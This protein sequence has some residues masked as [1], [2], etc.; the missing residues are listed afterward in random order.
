MLERNLATSRNEAKVVDDEQDSLVA[1]LVPDDVGVDL[2]DD[3]L[4]PP[5][6]I[7]EFDL[8]G[9]AQTVEGEVRDVPLRGV[10]DSLARTTDYR[11]RRCRCARKAHRAVPGASSIGRDEATLLTLGA[12]YEPR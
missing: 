12:A 4:F 9:E 7:A 6:S 2:V 10:R 8:Y 11:A 3:L 5:G 1:R